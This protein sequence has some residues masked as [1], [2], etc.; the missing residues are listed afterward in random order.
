[1]QV[2]ALRQSLESKYGR[3][4]W[5][6][7][8]QFLWSSKADQ[9]PSGGGNCSQLVDMQPHTAWQGRLT[10]AGGADG[11]P[12]MPPP[13]R[14]ASEYGQ[15]ADCGSLVYAQIGASGG[16]ASELSV[17]LFKPGAMAS[18]DEPSSEGFEL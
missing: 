17:V 9:L 14:P 13:S 4:A 16:A 18:D 11:Y 2:S 15:F 12:L 8:N 6:S 10:L 1:M 7:G 3:P 5:S